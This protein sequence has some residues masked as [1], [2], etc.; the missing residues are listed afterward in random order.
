MALHKEKCTMLDSFFNES[1]AAWGTEALYSRGKPVKELIIRILYYLCIVTYRTYIC[2]I[3][4]RLLGSWIGRLGGLFCPWLWWTEAR[5]FFV[6]FGKR[7]FVSESL[8]L[9]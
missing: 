9:L 6:K 2:T 8:V 4:G 3:L 7:P 1:V 5:N